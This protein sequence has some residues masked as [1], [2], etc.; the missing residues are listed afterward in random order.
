MIEISRRR[1]MVAA[2]ATCLGSRAGQSLAVDL[3]TQKKV[4]EAIVRALDFL[5][6]QQLPEGSWRSD[7]YGEC[8]AATSLACM[9]FMAAG[10]IPGKAPMA[11]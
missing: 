11:T 2:L 7:S 5:A 10:H 4:D 3:D 6:S 1:M 9:A 8:T